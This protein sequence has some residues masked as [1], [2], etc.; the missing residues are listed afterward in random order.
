LT[1]I[2][3]PNACGKSTLLRALARMLPA[4]RGQVELDGRPIAS[5]PPKEV[6]RRLGLL[7]QSP[8]AP[9]GI[10]V[11]DLVAR[12][13]YPHQGVLRQWS[14]ADQQAVDSALLR[15][16]VSELADRMVGELSG[17]Q[18]QRVWI[19]MALAQQTPILL[20]D[21]PTT[22]LDIAHQVEVLNLARRLRRDGHTI[23]MVLHELSLAFRCATNLIVMSAGRIVAQGKV[24]E[25]VTADLIADVYNL[26]CQIISDPISG[27]P[28]VLPLDPEA[29]ALG[30]EP[31]LSTDPASTIEVS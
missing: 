30:F 2:V 17:G 7:P 23:V 19:A 6:A 25:I 14:D 5:Y 22:Y 11:E 31:A 13:R 9:D 20:L 1:V 3:G 15:A 29:D 26:P 16:G 18:R 10:V 28:L 27:R 21:E 24:N 4:R 12:G 8:V